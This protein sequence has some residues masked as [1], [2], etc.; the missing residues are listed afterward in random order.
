MASAAPMRVDDLVD[1]Q[2][3]GSFNLGLLV[4]SFLA[5]FAEGFENAALGIAAPHLVREW[6]VAASAM[7][8]MLSA[9]LFGILLGA[10]LFG[11]LGDR[12][13]RRFVIIVGCFVFGVTTL[14]VVAAQ[15][16]QQIAVLRFLTGVGMGGLMSNAVALNSEL[17]PRRLRA[18]LVILMFLGITLGGSVPGFVGAWLVPEHGWRMLFWVG[19]LFPLLVCAGLVAFLPESVKFLAMRPGREALLLRTLRRMRPELALA[20]DARFDVATAAPARQ[21]SLAPLFSGGLASFTLLLWFTFSVTLMAN[22]FLNSWMA[23]LFEAKGISPE[24]AAMITTTYHLG[25]AFGGIAMGMLLDRWGFLAVVGML[26]VAAP[27]LLLISVPGLSPVALAVLVGL[28]G[29]F[30]LGAQFG[31]N[32]AAGIIY[33]TA[34][35]SKGV[36][37]AFAVGRTGSVLGPIVGAILIGMHLPLIWLLA[38]IAAPLLIGA[39]AALALAQLSKR[40]FG[41]WSLDERPAAAVAAE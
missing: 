29:F 12:Y 15:D 38:A 13:G 28:A 7:G 41:G 8:P 22:H 19:G 30:V 35:R 25:A 17:S 24:S 4:W 21:T 23:V 14:G 6:G 39:V 16:V 3:F 40:R 9:S 27:V 11:F 36:G 18:R 34:C 20:D 1:G 33:P 2:K 31:N 37:M 5:M 32:A 26:S 10:P